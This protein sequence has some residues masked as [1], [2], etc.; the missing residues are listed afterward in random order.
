MINVLIG[1]PGAGK[2]YEAVVYHVLPAL[3]SGRQVVTN[4][5]LNLDAIA[6]QVPGGRDLVVKVEQSLENPKPFSSVDDYGS[7]WRGE[8]GVGPLYVIDECHKALPKGSTSRLVEEWYAEHRHEGA[9]VLLI[10]QGYGKISAAIRDMIQ[11]VYRVRKATA[12]GMQNRYIRKVQDGPRGEI[13]NEATRVYDPKHYKLYKS[14]TKTV[15]GVAE[16]G[17][18]DVKPIWRHWSVLGACAVIPLGILGLVLAGSPFSVKAPDPQPVAQVKSYEYV[19]HNQRQ[20]QPLP[21]SRQTIVPEV[22]PDP[23]KHPFSGLGLHISAYLYSEAKE[24]TMYSISASQ[25]GQRVF[26][27]SDQDL[28]KAGYQVEFLTPCLI[29]LKFDKFEDYLTCDAPRQAVPL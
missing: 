11:L 3:L 10:T 13:V 14:H 6:D 24:K 21:E 19:P 18:K 8:G 16:A 2:S 15:G 29:K 5:P 28:V 25:N 12:L 1:P 27:M 4:L 23:V 26:R 9:D 20:S 17:A 7:E 22:K